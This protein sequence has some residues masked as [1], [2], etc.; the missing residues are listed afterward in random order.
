MPQRII[1]L[2]LSWIWSY[3]LKYIWTDILLVF[4]VLIVAIC[5]NSGIN[6]VQIRL[7]ILFSFKNILRRN[8][9][10]LRVWYIVAR[11]SLSM[12]SPLSP[13]MAKLYREFITEIALLTAHVLDRW[14]WLHL[15][16]S[17]SSALR[18]CRNRVALIYLSVI[19]SSSRWIVAYWFLHVSCCTVLSKWMPD[20]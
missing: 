9:I 13:V 10:R 8:R 3:L 1:D 15:M 5:V 17:K 7:I 18:L 6:C 2:M 4:A 20:S 12:N 16:E 19:V 14:S 11:G